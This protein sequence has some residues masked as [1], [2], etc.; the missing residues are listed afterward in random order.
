MIFA[1]VF[2]FIANVKNMNN[3]MYFVSG[4]FLCCI[5][6]YTSYLMRSEGY[7]RVKFE[8]IRYSGQI[9][10][11][12][13]VGIFIWCLDVFVG[14]PEGSLFSLVGGIVFFLCLYLS[15]DVLYYR[16]VK[17]DPE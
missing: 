17:G 11:L 6:C 12:L 7:F 8:H 14:I 3:G 16:F 10:F 9:V 5:S 15:T 13:I 1:G 4:F 2:W